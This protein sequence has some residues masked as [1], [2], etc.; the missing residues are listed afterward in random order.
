MYIAY[1]DENNKLHMIHDCEEQYFGSWGTNHQCSIVIKDN[2]VIEEYCDWT[3]EE[4]DDDTW[5]LDQQVL[6]IVDFTGFNLKELV[7]QHK[8]WFKIFMEQANE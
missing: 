7:S 1:H 2:Q 8:Q 4:P 6:G 3:P 5:T